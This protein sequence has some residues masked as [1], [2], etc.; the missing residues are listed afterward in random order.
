MTGV[1]LN[2]HSSSLK[3]PGKNTDAQIVSEYLYINGIWLSCKLV[4]KVDRG[5]PDTSFNY[6]GKSPPPVLQN[7]LQ[8]PLVTLWVGNS[9]STFPC[10]VMGRHQK[11]DGKKKH[12]ATSCIT[13]LFTEANDRTI[14][15]STCHL[16]RSFPTG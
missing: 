4:S 1:K 7:T 13:I 9:F 10:M 6:N 2:P 15:A 11:G 16:S 3:L 14:E 8:R 5:H 12:M